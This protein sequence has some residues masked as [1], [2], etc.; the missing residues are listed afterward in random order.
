M[1]VLTVLET[2]K[3]Q[4][5]YLQ[6]LVKVQKACQC[7]RDKTFAMAPF[8]VKCENLLRTVSLIFALDFAV[9]EVLTFERLDV[10]KLDQGRNG[11]TR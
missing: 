9:S 2:L 8:D 6:S 5:F 4:M 11:T 10:A 1:L 7:H 3:F